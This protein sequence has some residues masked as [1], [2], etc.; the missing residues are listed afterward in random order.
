MADIL[1]Q[2]LS[3]QAKQLG[4][5]G[6]MSAVKQLDH[7]PRQVIIQIIN[8][9]ALVVKGEQSPESVIKLIYDT[10][11]TRSTPSATSTSVSV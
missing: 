6:L 4:H 3:L 2:R 7:Q 9:L 11:Q 8:P 5:A 10:L 1:F